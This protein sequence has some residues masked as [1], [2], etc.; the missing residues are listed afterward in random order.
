MRP[1]N[2]LIAPSGS[3]AARG[4]AYIE[5]LSNPGY[6]QLADGTAPIAGFVTRPVLVGGPTLGDAIFPNRLE[7]PFQDGQPISLEQAEQVSAEGY[8]PLGIN[9]NLYSGTGNGGSATITAATP[10]GTKISFYNGQFCVAN[11]GQYYEWMLQAIEPAAVPTNGF[12]CRFT[13]VE[14]NIK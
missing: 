1:Y 4:I 12:R 6:A 8:D 7:L 5:S 2:S 11:T 3:G 10:T 13:K 9:G 14:G